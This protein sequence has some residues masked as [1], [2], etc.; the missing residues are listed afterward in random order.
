LEGW[1]EGREQQQQQACPCVQ[2]AQNQ[3]DL[4]VGGG[5]IPGIS[6]WGTT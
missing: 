4:W 5:K 1:G 3:C 6:N 2:L